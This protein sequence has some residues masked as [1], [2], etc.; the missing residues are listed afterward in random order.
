M[1]ETSRPIR[2]VKASQIYFF[3]FC[4][5]NA[6][7]RRTQ[8]SISRFKFPLWLTW[9]LGWCGHTENSQNFL[10]LTRFAIS[11][12]SHYELPFQRG[13]HCGHLSLA[14]VALLKG[15]KIPLFF[16]SSKLIFVIWNVANYALFR[17]N[18][19]K[20]CWCERFD[21]YHEYREGTSPP[22]VW[23]KKGVLLNF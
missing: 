15:S 23:A 12:F 3:L 18:F 17:A 22:E 7:C 14:L 1:G 9:W 13:H 6:N 8:R 20:I 19:G 11:T 2:S 4:V 5:S 10:I 16:S 21:K